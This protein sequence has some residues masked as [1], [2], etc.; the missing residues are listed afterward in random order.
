MRWLLVCALFLAAC[1]HDVRSQFPG[2]G[3]DPTGTVVIMLTEPGNDLVVTIDGIL[4]A[5]AE[6][7]QRIVIDHVPV[8]F[9]ELVVAASG[10]DKTLRIWVGSDHA[11]TVAL[12]LPDGGGA[13]FLKTLAATLLTIVVYALIH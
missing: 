2:G 7:T 1:V 9:R 6:R 5:E 13:G 11:T 12:G 10:G 4:I 8:G 3:G